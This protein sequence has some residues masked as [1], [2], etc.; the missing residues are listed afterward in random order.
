MDENANEVHSSIL[1]GL[2]HLKQAVSSG[3]LSED[4]IL[5]AINIAQTN[6][7]FQDALQNM[8]PLND[9]AQQQYT[10]ILTGTCHDR[11]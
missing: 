2:D 11:H 3:L 7:D 5:E 9:W 8:Q 1:K 10:K 6:A 4:E